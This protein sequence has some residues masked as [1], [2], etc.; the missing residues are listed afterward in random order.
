MFDNNNVRKNNYMAMGPNDDHL[1]NSYF[2]L[3]YFEY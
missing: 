3:R 2:E 1:Q